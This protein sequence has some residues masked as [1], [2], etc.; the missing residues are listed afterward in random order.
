M[1]GIF[2]FMEVC[3]THT[4]NIYRFGLRSLLPSE[5]TLISGPGCPVC[6]MPQE[7]IDFFLVLVKDPQI[8]LCV[9]GDLLRVPG[10][11]GSLWKS[12]AQGARIRLIYSPMEALKIA[13]EFPEA[14]VVLIG[15]GFET[16]APAYAA[17]I[18]EA[19]KQGLKNFFFF[20]SLRLMPPVL[21]ALI[22]DPNLH[23]DGFILPGH[24]S[25]IIGSKPY[26]FI[27]REFKLPG[28]ITGFTSRDILEGLTI[29]LK[30]VKEKRS[31][32]EIQYRRVVSPDG[33]PRALELIRKVFRPID[34]RWRGIG[35]IPKSRLVLSPEYAN[36]SIEENKGV[37]L[38]PVPEPPG[39][40]CGDVLRGRI[41]PYECPLFGKI[42]T[43]ENPRGPC[44]VS[45]EGACAACFRFS[46]YAEAALQKA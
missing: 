8:I 41:S 4:V 39:C 26:E 38:E 24:V 6:V 36:F 37:S 13:K 20:S 31:T 1:S 11:H 15:V 25:T 2:R 5:I 19:K 18:L 12:R 22:S 40:R 45:S 27:A 23:I 44:M 7:E 43:P 46:K 10:S 29:L 30:L 32:I 9:F 42:C 28:V 3:G 17:T 14:Q 21:R 35:L 33:N 16:T 34:G